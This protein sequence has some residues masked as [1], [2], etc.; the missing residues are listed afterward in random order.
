MPSFGKRSLNNLEKVHPKLKA[1]MLAAIERFDFMVISGHRTKEE[2]MELYKVGRIKDNGKWK[3]IGKTVTKLDGLS[4][5]SKHNYLPSL[6]VDIVPY[7]GKGKNIDWGNISAF[8]QMAEVVKE[9]A[10][11]L[12]IAITWGGDWEKFRDYP[13]F[14]LKEV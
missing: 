14:E 11:K 7:P 4:K 12:N 9:E 8:K 10:A 5:L 3:I 13:H 6:A 2:Q 1:I